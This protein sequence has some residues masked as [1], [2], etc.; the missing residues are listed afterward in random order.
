MREVLRRLD[1]TAPWVIWGHSH[2]AGPWPRDDRS[3]WTT[4]AGTRLINSAAG[5]T[6]RTSS[7][8]RPNQSPYW[9]GTAIR[10]RDDGPPELV[11]LLGDRGHDELARRSRR[12]TTRG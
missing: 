4:P 1:V 5:S 8:A 12:G 2:R 3:E 6:S 9:P 11:R 7:P 10:S